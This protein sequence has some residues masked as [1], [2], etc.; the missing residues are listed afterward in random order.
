MAIP[1]ARHGASPSTP[2]KAQ[3]SEL[4]TARRFHP[5]RITAVIFVLAALGAVVWSVATNPRL[6]LPLIGHY[7]FAGFVLRGAWVTLWLTIV[8]MTVGIAGG[9]LLAVMRLSPNPVLAWVASLYIWMFRGIPIFI[10]ITFWGFLGAFYPTVRIGVPFTGIT[11]FTTPTSLVV[12]T[13]IAAVLGLGLNQ[14]AYSAEIIRAGIL[15][16]NHGQVEA[17]YSLGLSPARTT[18]RI[19]LPQA[20]RVIIPH[21]GNETINMLKTTAL[22]SIISGD[23]LLTAVQ[24]VYTQNFEIIPLLAVAGI[25]YLALTTLLGIP[26]AYLE[27][28]FGRGT[29]S[30]R[31]AAFQSAR[32]REV[33]AR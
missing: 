26:Q 8:A 18:R 31:P 7:L 6:N 19:V 24:S 4:I 10:Q 11:V 32:L 12:T 3:P 17:A 1:P 15:S 20:M 29:T 2:R 21:M 33:G 22:V 14:I 28:R 16:V 9:T 30:R 25:W 13:T 27:H 23:D 5:G